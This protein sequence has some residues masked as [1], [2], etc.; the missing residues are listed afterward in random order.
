M[1]KATNDAGIAKCYATLV[2]KQRSEHHAMKVRLVESSHSVQ[3]DVPVQSGHIPP[4]IIKS[5][6]DVHVRPGQ[7]C[8]I[9]V[10][11]TGVPKPKVGAWSINLSENILFQ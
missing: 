1:V 7:P 9:E 4:E 8:N 5:F 2:V 10:V 6:H 11:I 3:T